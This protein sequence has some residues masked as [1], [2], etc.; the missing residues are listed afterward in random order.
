M[1]WRRKLKR[2]KRWSDGQ[3]DPNKEM[4][5]EDVSK[6]R[7]GGTKKRERK[8]KNKKKKNRKKKERKKERNLV[9]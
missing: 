9:I 3:T 1:T 8:T 6:K 7:E 2:K 5:C 4:R